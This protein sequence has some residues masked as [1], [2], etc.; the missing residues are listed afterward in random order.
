MLL[1]TIIRS[2]ACLFFV[3]ALTSCG[4]GGG[5]DGGGGG[6]SGSDMA[7]PQG[8]LS[9]AMVSGDSSVLRAEDADM[10]S[11][12]AYA[13]YQSLKASQ[14]NLISSFYNGLSTKFELIRHSYMIQPSLENTDNVTPLVIGD[15]GNVIASISTVGGGRIAG[16]GYDIL[17]GF[18][19]TKNRIVGLD[20]AISNEVP[21]TA[22]QADHQPVFKRVLAW[23]V[24]GDPLRAL[25]QPS[26][27][28]L[29]IAWSN[30]PTSTSNSVMYT[31]TDTKQK[32]YKP[33]A[34]EGLAALNVAFNNLPC[35]PLSAPV[36][37][38]AA[39]AH[40][41]V[42]GGIDNNK[43]DILPTQL[44]RIKE[45]VAARIP[46]L[47][48]NAHPSGG[49][50]NDYAWGS[51]DEEFLRLKA[52]GFANGASPD[53]SNY[54]LKDWV[55][56]EITPDQRSK[57]NDSLSEGI[58]KRIAS[59]DF[60]TTYDWTNCT[61]DSDCV[62]PQGFI[63]DIAT[64][65]EK[66]RVL[67]NDMNKK[68]QN[69][70]D[71]E[72]K[73][74]S[75]QQLVLW[76]DAYRKNIKYPINKLKQ[77]VEFQKAYIADA[78]I[79]YVRTSGS[80]QTDLGNLAGAD[81][82]Q[83]SGSSTMENVTVTLPGSDGATAVGR[84]VLP[85]QALTIQL[86]NAPAVGTFKFF[87]N[88]AGEANTKLFTSPVDNNGN[89]S[90]N[91]GYRRPRLPQSPDFPL[92]TQPIT[93]VSPY[94]GLLQLRY[95][96]ATAKS[97]VLQIQGT[98]SQPF[99]DDTQ[100]TPVAATFMNDFQSSKLGW[101]EIK[102]T[103]VDIHSLISLTKNLL[104]PDPDPKKPPTP[105]SKPYYNSGTKSIDMVKYLAE[106]NKYVMVDAYRLAGFQNGTID[107]KLNQRVLDFCTSYDWKCE[108]LNIHKLPKDIQR[109]NYHLDYVA[110]CGW[111]CSG[112][113]ITSGG[114][115]EPRGW[116][117]SHELGHNLVRFKIYDTTTTEVANNIYPLHKKW[118]L[119]LDLK[120]DAIGYSNELSDA[121]IVFET[122]KNAYV[123]SGNKFT[124]AKKDVWVNGTSN[125]MLYFYLQW[126]LLYAELIKNQNP[127][128]PDSEAIEAGWDIYTLMLLN[129]RQIDA[130]TDWPNDKSKLGFS[131]YNKSQYT[132]NK[133]GTRNGDMVDGIYLHHDY[134]LIV[135]S[136]ITGH[137]QTPL[138]DFWGVATSSDAKA[139]VSALR[140]SNNNPLPPQPVKF[141]AV[142]C[143]D[144][145]RG[146]Q[147]VDMTSANPVFPWPDEFK[148][149]I[150]VTPVPPATTLSNTQNKSISTKQNTHTA[151]C[152]AMR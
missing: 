64:P 74:K 94:G 90:L 59:N 15:K 45:I 19:T 103:Y 22:K 56:N 109:Q 92:S 149:L 83:V 39:K 68:G 23:L 112:N 99:Y 140:D 82:N 13:N 67:V 12:Q 105:V 76:A 116:G 33:F 107:L 134:M 146:F 80:A 138:F 7:T 40:L 96:G 55:A 57:K 24:Y 86:Q 26:S 91:V 16:Y 21:I 77:P 69:L 54:Y 101:L 110:N 117:E 8:R 61:V 122:L 137:D 133:P 49:G 139:Q 48:L 79:A 136:L 5:G 66:I 32:V 53:K 50:P 95:A 124:K 41:V 148:N 14:N 37:E 151:A 36:T 145:F 104:L 75:L 72:V 30:L 113:P 18:D 114:G 144:D 3:L 106:A 1:P 81:V 73:N 65:V 87:M 130:S 125:G 51:Y 70:F 143:S 126:P 118:R 135:L 78:L 31:S 127:S 119:L 132:S 38:C 35:D 102:T 9:A 142:R 129:L 84:Y 97:V 108:D 120:R 2:F 93:I 29:K 28:E 60:S 62:K 58:L 150:D 25:P 141:Y 43:K 42:I 11:S 121:Q 47:Y 4:G 34:V 20:P 147:A 17:A 100:G 115:F 128:M 152:L 98:A 46:I 44:A 123:S 10:V 63:D 71:P 27:T 88:T 6:G 52:M 131:I 85:G 111:M 89:P